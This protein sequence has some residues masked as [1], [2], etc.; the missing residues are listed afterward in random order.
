M[1]IY[2]HNIKIAKIE[3]KGISYVTFGILYSYLLHRNDNCTPFPFCVDHYMKDSKQ[4]GEDIDYH[5]NDLQRT[6]SGGYATITNLYDIANE[7]KELDNKLANE[8]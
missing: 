2:N 3:F 4:R 7:L 5:L 6:L 1:K 8:K